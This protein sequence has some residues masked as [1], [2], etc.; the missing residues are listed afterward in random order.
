MVFHWGLLCPWKCAQ[1]EGRSRY[2]FCCSAKDETGR[3]DV[4]ESRENPDLSFTLSVFLAYSL[5]CQACLAWSQRKPTGIGITECW[6]RR[7]TLSP[8]NGSKEEGQ[9]ISCGLLHRYGREWRTGFGGMEEALKTGFS[10]WSALSVP[11]E[12]L[13]ELGAGI[14]RCGGIGGK[15]VSPNG[16]GG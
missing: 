8:G 1:S 10:G 14:K 15:C 7:S 13:P 5:L 4:E 3:L 12:C 2:I 9:P 6:R 16:D 11:R